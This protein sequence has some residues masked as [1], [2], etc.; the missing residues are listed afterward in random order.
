[1]YAEIHYLDSTEGQIKSHS[2][3]TFVGWQW[4]HFAL[5]KPH[6][7]ASAAHEL[8]LFSAVWHEDH[9]HGISRVRW[10][11]GRKSGL[12]AAHFRL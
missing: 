3:N 11:K 2:W 12:I 10:L 4:L 1:M 6:F 9:H 8:M 7:C 5:L